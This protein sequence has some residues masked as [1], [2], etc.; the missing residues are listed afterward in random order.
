MSGVLISCNTP[1]SA[2]QA[3][4]QLEHLLSSESSAPPDAHSS[5]LNG[6]ATASEVPPPAATGAP[7]R[8]PPAARPALRSRILAPMAACL[9]APSKMR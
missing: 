3:P 8:P 1:G 7:A 6:S 2:W 9:G 4:R 5:S